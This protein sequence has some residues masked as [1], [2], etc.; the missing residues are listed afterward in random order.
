MA[1]ANDGVG[2][3]LGTLN[4]CLEVLSRSGMFRNTAAFL[5]GILTEFESLG[6]GN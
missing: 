3:N 6:I 1:M 2:P 5:S 4:A